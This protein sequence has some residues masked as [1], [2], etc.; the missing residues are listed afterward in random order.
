VNNA[1]DYIYSS[2][3]DYTGGKGILPITVIDN[4]WLRS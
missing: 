3:V 2:A 1:E 4:V